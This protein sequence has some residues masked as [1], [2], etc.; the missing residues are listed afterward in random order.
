MPSVDGL[1]SGIKFNDIIDALINADRASTAVVEKRKATFQTRLEAV[2]SF[3]TK[4]LSHQLDLAALN[5]PA[6]FN[7]RQASSTNAAV[8]SG[9]ASA[10]AIPGTYQ[11]EVTSVAK[12]HQLA[13][14]AQPDSTTPLGAG[15]VS[16]QLGSGGISTIAISAG[17]SSLG[18]IAQAINDAAAGVKASVLNDGSGYRLLLTSSATGTASAITVSGSGALASTF[19]GLSTLQAASDAQVKIGSGAGALLITQSSNTFTDVLPGVSMTAGAVGTATM[20]VGTDTASTITS[21]KSF[22]TSYNDLVQFMK[23]NASYDVS[24]NKAGPLFSEGDVRNRFNS[25]TQS[26]LTSVNGRPNGLSS[27]VSV[28]ISIDRA[29]GRLALDQGVLADKLAT[30]ADGVGRIFANGGVSSDSGVRFGLLTDKTQ[31]TSPF[32]VDV[33]QPSF[34]PTVNGT[35]DVDASTVIDGTNRDLSINVNGRDYAVTLASGT[36]TGAQLATHLQAVLDQK[37][38]TVSD[39]VK[40][41]FT[42]NRLALT[43]AVYG[44]AGTVQVAAASTANSVL[45]LAVNR[46]YGQ[47]VVGNINGVAA[48]G[49][50]QSLAG[51][52]G[53]AAEGLRLSITATA[54]VSG[55]TLTVTKGLA[56][57]AGERV[58]AMTD[59]TTGVLVQKQDSISKS[60]DT[61]T[62]SITAADER[63]ALRRIRYQKQ[64]QAMETSIQKSNSLSSYLAGQ[65]K[66]F[67]NAAKGA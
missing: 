16:L 6:L 21:I 55:A 24:T 39:K 52:A 1:A 62:K 58:K 19:T 51:I 48:T 9:T 47:D 63:L 8:L 56:Q 33:I 67:E 64:F 28:G 34:Q 66:G 61:L 5:R 36:Y 65:I 44:T 54:A 59:G 3:N 7:V 37:I 38:T 30:D 22:V 26:L 25:I 23:D 11:F 29:T 17:T 45:R 42:A 27:L 14:V 41:G 43:G 12:A 35:A 32:T 4:L 50:G 53:T 13:T 40:V 31:T 18:G 49:A 60:I 10:T 15:T 2:R 20:T 46:T 57:L